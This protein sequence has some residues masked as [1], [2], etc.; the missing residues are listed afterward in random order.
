MPATFSTHS[1]RM[2]VVAM[3]SSFSFGLASIVWMMKLIKKRDNK[4]LFF[5][6][7]IVFLSLIVACTL[8]F[9]VGECNSDLIGCKDWKR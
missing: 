7:V 2:L 1:P 6:R 3:I 8:G 4:S 9:R 5:W